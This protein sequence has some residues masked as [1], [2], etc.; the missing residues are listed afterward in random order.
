MFCASLD[1]MSEEKNYDV[2]IIEWICVEWNKTSV[3]TRRMNV[4]VE[5]KVY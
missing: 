3:I 4:N 2:C 5:S 1:I